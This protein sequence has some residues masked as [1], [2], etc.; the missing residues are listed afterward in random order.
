MNVVVHNSS[1]HSV[2][3]S[4]GVPQGSVI[5]PFLLKKI[6]SNMYF[7]NM[8]KFVLFADDVKLYL[9][10]PSDKSSGFGASFLSQNYVSVLHQRSH[11]WGFSFSVNKCAQIH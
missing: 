6:I 2:N 8:S 11:S 5:S 9:A 4:S 10:L 7:V 3:I 1:S